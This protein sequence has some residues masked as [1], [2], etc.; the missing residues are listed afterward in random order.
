MAHISKQIVRIAL[1]VL[2]F[3]FVC[4][5]FLPIVTQQETVSKETT[6]SK[7][8]T[9][10]VVPLLLKEK[11]EKEDTESLSDSGAAAL[12]DFSSHGNNL[13]AVHD[14]KQSEVLQEHCL[15]RL[16]LFKIF[17]TLLI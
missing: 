14:N 2:L 17:C 6:I 8:H 12:L 9:S 15:T 10:I 1:L 7:M 3:Q 11:D 16:P 13:T 5:A 4:P